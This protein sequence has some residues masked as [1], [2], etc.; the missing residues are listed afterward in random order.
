MSRITGLMLS[1]EYSGV[2]VDEAQV[3]GGRKVN[4]NIWHP[5]YTPPYLVYQAQIT[6]LYSRPVLLMIRQFTLYSLPSS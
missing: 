1:V 2:E 6:R 3:G 4:R 5:F